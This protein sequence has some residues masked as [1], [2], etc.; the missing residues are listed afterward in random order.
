[1]YFSR[2]LNMNK[3]QGWGGSTHMNMIWQNFDLPYRLFT[4]FASSL[5]S[6]TWSP[7]AMPSRSQVSFS[8]PCLSIVVGSTV[9]PAPSHHPCWGAGAV[10][11]GS[12]RD[13]SPQTS[14]PASSRPSPMTSVGLPRYE[15]SV[16]NECADGRWLLADDSLGGVGRKGS[17]G[18]QEDEFEDLGFL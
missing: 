7:R 1:M 3:D 12:S 18:V 2:R 5:E 11:I 14:F 4:S 6:G 8:G 10:S 13:G 9:R 17:H 16:E 15:G